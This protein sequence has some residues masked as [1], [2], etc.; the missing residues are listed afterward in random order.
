MAFSAATYAALLSR[1]K[2]IIDESIATN[3]L[4]AS[5][6]FTSLEEAKNAAATAGEYGSSSTPYFFGSK[7]LVYENSVA[8][9]YTIQN[10]GVLVADATCTCEQLGDGTVFIMVDSVDYPVSNAESEVTDDVIAVLLNEDNRTYIS[11]S[12]SEATDDDIEVS[13]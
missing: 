6:Y 8:T 2:R 12:E 4:P 1:V 13:Y 3:S 11:I 7:I 9:W 10:P 5:S